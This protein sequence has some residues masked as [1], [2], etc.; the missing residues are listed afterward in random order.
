MS[1]R[2]RGT[3]RC[4]GADHDADGEPGASGGGVAGLRI[5]IAL[6]RAAKFPCGVGMG[7]FEGGAD[8]E[9]GKFRRA[10]ERA[11]AVLEIVGKEIEGVVPVSRLVGLGHG[12]KL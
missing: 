12:G 8:E 2:C 9:V 7:N 5:A 11:E 1:R 10:R 3:G 4:G 6:G